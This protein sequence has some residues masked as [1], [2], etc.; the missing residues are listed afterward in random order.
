MESLIY[1]ITD[2]STQPPE[3]VA[4]RLDALAAAQLLL[5]QSAPLHYYQVTCWDVPAEQAGDED[6]MVFKKPGDAFLQDLF[7]T[8]VSATAPDLP[9][10]ALLEAAK[11]VLESLPDLDSERDRRLSDE[12]LLEKYHRWAERA[13]TA[14]VRLKVAVKFVEAIGVP[15]HPETFFCETAAER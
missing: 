12:E 11:E 6:P 3:M 5:E 8:P 4:G 1:S 10:L 2:S 13:E 14:R 7:E 9:H 15:D